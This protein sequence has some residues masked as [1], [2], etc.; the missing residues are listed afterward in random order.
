MLRI[1]PALSEG[2]ISQARNL[3][4]EYASTLAGDVCLKDFDRE[5]A[6]LPGLY[7]PP[8][9]RLLLA[10]QESAESP[11]EPIGCAALRRLRPDVCEMKRLYIRSAFRGQG[12]ARQLVN[13]L[14]GEARSIGYKSMV[15]DTL[16]SMEGAQKLYRTLGFREIPSYQDNPI[17]GAFFFELALR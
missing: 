11:R 7:A 10:I 2:T 6:S 14:I 12:A 15:L 17:P 16:P 3:F 1:Q 8:S 9:G 4:R 5:L 13:E